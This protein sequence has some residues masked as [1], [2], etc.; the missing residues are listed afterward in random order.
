MG[1]GKFWGGSIQLQGPWPLAHPPEGEGLVDVPSKPQPCLRSD[2]AERNQLKACSPTKQPHGESSRRHA[3]R[4]EEGGGEAEQN[5][6]L[7][8]APSAPQSLLLG[9]D[10]G[11]LREGELS[12]HPFGSPGGPG[13]AQT[14]PTVPHHSLAQHPGKSWEVPVPQPAGFYFF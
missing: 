4:R 12:C 2:V 13:R 5:P 3:E 8:D 14:R 9:G 7:K 11:Q 1:L 10:C 6:G